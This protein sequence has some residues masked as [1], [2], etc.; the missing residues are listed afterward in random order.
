MELMVTSRTTETNDERGA[1]GAVRHARP[2]LV[3]V[4]D[5]G[6]CGHGP[7]KV[8]LSRS[9]GDRVGHH[10]D[11]GRPCL[12]RRHGE[13]RDAFDAAT[14]TILWRTELR[15]AGG[16]GVITYL[17]DG[18]QRVAFVAGIRSPAFPVSPA[19]RRLSSSA[20]ESRPFAWVPASDLMDNSPVDHHHVASLGWVIRRGRVSLPVAASSAES[21][22]ETGCRPRSSTDRQQPSRSKH[23]E[24]VHELAGAPRYFRRRNDQKELPLIQAGGGFGQAIEPNTIQ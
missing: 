5:G 15:G 18:K 17:I 21:C 13:A 12:C 2:E 6:R 24:R 20:S 3:G 14:G 11:P 22:D 4:T 23:G 7:D 10:T 16:G 19:A 1:G 8:A 9:R